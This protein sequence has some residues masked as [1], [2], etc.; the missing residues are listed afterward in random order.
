MN[1]VG[2]H[3][4]QA[5]MILLITG[6]MLAIVGCSDSGPKGAIGDAGVYNYSPSVIETG[7]IRQFWWCGQA[8]NPSNPSQHTDTIRYE[9]VNLVTGATVGPMTV[10]AETPNTWDSVFTCNPKVI[11]GTFNN[12]LGDGQTYTYALYYVATNDGETNNIGV[13]FSN[14]G[15]TWKKYP[16]PVIR[17]TSPTGYGVGQPALYNTDQKS[18]ITMFYEDSIPTTHHVAATSTDGVHFT[19]Q[20]TLTANGLDPDYAEPGWGDMAYDAST[21]YWYAIF[22]RPFR[23]PST[24]GGVTERGQLGVELY[25]IPKDALLTG[26]SPWQQLVI[27]DTNATGYESNF[28]A[29]FVR[30]PYGTIN[31]ASYPEVDFYTSVSYPP[32]SWNAT[33]EEAGTSARIG[34]WILLP[35]KWSPTTDFLL[36]LTD[37]YNGTQHEVTSGLIS[38]DGGFYEQQVFGHIYANPLHGATVPIYSCKG[39]QVD[40]FVSLDPACEGKRILGKD[41]YVYA[42][43]V[44]GLALIPIY[45]CSTGHDHFVSTSSGC[46]GQSMEEFLGYLAP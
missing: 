3:F 1:V 28:I 8:T 24:T 31:T 29:G 42:N 7:N 14:D 32:P 20:G 5:A 21:G 41:G 12:P 39:G 38:P 13:A 17:T 46:G 30:D 11:G 34:T 43:P 25:K 26:T 16:Q 15:I 27:M 10:L 6:T 18:A 22:N 37:Y 2:K 23:D 19:V 45:R 4:L 40:Y 9:S 33:P 35:M 44:S 36:P